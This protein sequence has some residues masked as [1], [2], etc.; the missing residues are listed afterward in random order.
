M[1]DQ[2]TQ[3]LKTVRTTVKRI[4][5]RLDLIDERQTDHTAALTRVEQRLGSLPGQQKGWLNAFG[6][7]LTGSTTVASQLDAILKRLPTGESAA[8][9]GQMVKLDD[10]LRRQSQHAEASAQGLDALDDKLSAMRSDVGTL[11]SES[12]ET[13]DYLRFGYERNSQAIQALALGAPVV[14]Q[15]SSNLG[16]VFAQLRDQNQT[17]YDAVI[18]VSAE[19]DASLSAKLDG[20]ALSIQSRQDAQ[21][22]STRQSID[23]LV[24]AVRGLQ[25][26]GPEAGVLR[27]RVEHSITMTA[28]LATMLRGLPDRALATG[29][30]LKTLL[31]RQERVAARD[32]EALAMAVRALRADYAA[33]SERQDKMATQAE[34]NYLALTAHMAAVERQLNTLSG[35]LAEQGLAHNASED[36]ETYAITDMRD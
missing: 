34:T 27:G 2:L 15:S 16:P 31:D 23:V 6:D 8:A 21:Y 29:Q 25:G 1:A 12:R 17:T 28:D 24:D 19:L 20:H 33:F 36:G 18:D 4:R 22:H 3:V 30:Q 26:H 13:L 14:S 11:R 32:A 5:Q 35:Q 9:V 10:V 7:A